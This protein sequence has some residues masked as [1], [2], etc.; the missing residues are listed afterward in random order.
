[1]TFVPAQSR[2]AG[3]VEVQAAADEHV[4]G[5]DPDRPSSARV[6]LSPLLRPRGR[7]RIGQG[8]RTR[9]EWT[10]LD[11]VGGAA[12]ADSSFALAMQSSDE[13]WLGQF[14]GASVTS[15]RVAVAPAFAWQE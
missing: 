11:H 8:P 5:R 6:P 3:R 1:M 2:P 4:A 15:R 12:R 9:P 13:A 7:M 10:S 14:A